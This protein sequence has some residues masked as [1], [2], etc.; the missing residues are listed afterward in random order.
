MPEIIG[1]A[2]NQL[3]TDNFVPGAVLLLKIPS[4]MKTIIFWV[5]E[6]NVNAIMYTVTGSVDG[7]T[8]EEI[9][10]A[11]DV[12]KNGHEFT[13]AITDPYIYLDFQI[14]AKVGAAQ[15]RVTVYATGS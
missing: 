12:A 11:N 7:S 1:S 13:T 4:W 6:L 5:K 8:Y 2:V 14:K 15:G 3:T 10:A 9:I